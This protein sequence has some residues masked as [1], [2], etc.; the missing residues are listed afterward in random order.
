MAHA[1]PRRRVKR[2]DLRPAAVRLQG[3]MPPLTTA[4]SS[5]C[6]HITAYA[7]CLL[8]YGFCM[9]KQPPK[10]RTARDMF[11]DDRDRDTVRKHC[12]LRES[13]KMWASGHI[14]TCTTRIWCLMSS[15]EN[16][17][18]ID[19]LVRFKPITRQ[20]GVSVRVVE[21]HNTVPWLMATNGKQ[22]RTSRTW[23]H[24]NGCSVLRQTSG[25]C[26]ETF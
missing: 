25:H 21:A 24:A 9:C 19:I 14:V 6:R 7:S 8:N 10:T 26:L 4:S 5:R 17:F 15:V 11:H 20:P 23:P 3:A 16:A 13:L 1:V 12:L 22:D 18:D 2:R